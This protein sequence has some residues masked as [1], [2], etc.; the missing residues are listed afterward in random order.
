[1]SVDASDPAGESLAAALRVAA[2]VDGDRALRRLEELGAIG[3][4]PGGGVTRP[5]FS[6][7]EA[8]ATALVAG[9]AR[10]AG[11]TVAYDDI[12]NLFASTDGNAPGAAAVAAGSHLDSVPDGGRYDGPL[13]VVGALAAIEALRAAGVTPRRPLELI[14]WRCEE[15]VRFPSGRIGSQVFAGDLTIDELLPRGETFGLA[16]WL[17]RERDRPRRAPGRTLA[18]FLELH[19]EQGRRLEDAGAQLGVVTAVAAPTRLR[20]DITGAADH[21]GATPMGLR[22]DAL[23]AAAE[24]ILAVERAGFAARASDGV[25]TA[26]TIRAEPGAL[27]VVPGRVELALDLRGTDPRGIAHMAALIRRDGARIARRRGVTV[28]QTVLSR[29][30]PVAFDEATVTLVEDTI[31]ALGYS[32]LRLP[33]GAG[34]DAMTVAPHTPSAMLFV[35]SAGGVSHAPGE[36]TPPD[37]IIRGILA[38]AAA[39]TRLALT[40]AG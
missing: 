5:A 9:W 27:N 13:G 19:I 28:E 20:V 37:D 7:E 40:H 30:T 21:S 3:R 23:C 22:R 2:A 11:L 35:P 32:H 10:A 36:Y 6:E 39:W 17:E 12:G 25:A 31:R 8:R 16:G 24:L 29:A 15:P 1:M 34:H 38:L 14:V 4:R 18:A 26:V 33:S